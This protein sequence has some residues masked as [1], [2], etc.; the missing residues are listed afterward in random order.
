[1]TA[2]P[3][4]PKTLCGPARLVRAIIDGAGSRE[5]TNGSG[6]LAAPVAVSP[7]ATAAPALA[8]KLP[9]VSVAGAALILGCREKQV[10]N[11]FEDGS[12]QNAFD[13]SAAIPSHRRFIR[14]LS[15]SVFDFKAAVKSSLSNTDVVNLL[16]PAARQ[17]FSATE[18]AW[19]FACDAEHIHALIARGALQKLP[20]TGDAINQA[21]F[22][23]RSSLA[24][25]LAS[26]RIT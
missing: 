1:M 7:A 21:P 17:R 24:E 6:R 14:I 4:N 9:T 26:R 3:S 18:C 10:W 8:V 5:K 12:L 2:A 25:F 16:F 15:R 19:A 23:P 20:G 22:I 13:L 11:H